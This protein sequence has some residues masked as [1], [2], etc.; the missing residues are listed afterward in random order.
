VTHRRKQ[1]RPAITL[2]SY[3]LRYDDG[4]APNPYWGVCTLAICKPAIRRTASVGDW[5]VGLG[6][7]RSPC[8]D[9]SSKVVYAMHVTQV[10][11]LQEYDVYCGKSLRKKV[12]DWNSSDYRRMMGDCIYDFN[13]SRP[14]LRASVH[15]AGNRKT[16]LRGRNVLL[17]DYFYYFGNKP[18]ELPD[19]LRALIHGTQGHKSR[20]NDRYASRFVRWIEGEG[21]RNNVL[22]GQP[23]L[24]KKL[25]A[26][27]RSACRQLCSKRHIEIEH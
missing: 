10:V 23:Q 13:E 4:A 2:Y 12:P 26:V 16:D 1:G 24:K 11:T 6:S 8:G 15:G 7:K 25:A 21:F 17:S 27:R 14:R 9:I 5:V 22:L 19:D 20:A 3:C 18:V